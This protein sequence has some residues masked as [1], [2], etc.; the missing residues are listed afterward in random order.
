MRGAMRAV[1]G[2]RGRGT[3][4]S[5]VLS[6]CTCA[7]LLGLTATAGARVFHVGT[8]AGKKGKSSLQKA[9]EAPKGAGLHLVSKAP[10]AHDSDVVPHQITKH[11]AKWRKLSQRFKRLISP[12][13]CSCRTPMLDRR[14][15]THV[16]RLALRSRTSRRN[17]FGGTKKGL[18]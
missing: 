1:R 16:D 15:Q 9:V 6:M 18:C 5:L 4:L 7:A 2:L 12:E 3:K 14:C 13:V 11:T 17:S 10:G 8:F